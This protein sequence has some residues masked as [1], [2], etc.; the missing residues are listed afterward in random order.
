MTML[1]QKG[2]ELHYLVEKTYLMNTPRLLIQFY[3]M[4][5]VQKYMKLK[6]T[7]LIFPSPT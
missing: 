1:H 5:L 4:T 3:G 2:P 7:Q 6:T